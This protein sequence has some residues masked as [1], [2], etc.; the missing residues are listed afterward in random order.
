MGE[1]YG[2]FYT[3]LKLCLAYLANMIGMYVILRIAI[4]FISSGGVNVLGNKISTVTLSIVALALYSYTLMIIYY[5][6]SN[7]SSNNKNM[8]ITNAI[9]DSLTCGMLRVEVKNNMKILHASKGFVELMGYTSDYDVDGI[10][11]LGDYLVEGEVSKLNRLINDC[12]RSGE[13]TVNTVCSAIIKDGYGISLEGNLKLVGNVEKKA[14]R[15]ILDCVVVDM[16]KEVALSNELS[17]EK[18]RYRLISEYS[19][20]IIIEV[21]VHGVSM[22]T[23]SNFARVFGSIGC[24]EPLID[25]LKSNK[26]ISSDDANEIMTAAKRLL[27][28]EIQNWESEL[29]IKEANDEHHWY[30]VTIMKFT[31]RGTKLDRIMCKLTKIDKEVTDKNKLIE[32]ANKDALTGLLNKEAFM[33]EVNT[34]IKNCKAGTMI[35]FDIDNFKGLNDTLGHLIGDKAL[36]DVAECITRNTREDDVLSRF[37]GDEYCIFL[38][39]ISLSAS[40]QIIERIRGNV[41]KQYKDE[42]KT[43]EVTISIGA[44]GYPE[45]GNNARLLLQKADQALYKAK[46]SGKNQAYFM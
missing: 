31:D 2:K 37:G 35:F 6:V 39:N 1:K 9:T 15:L 5:I 27:A 11:Y 44:V 34:R 40:R 10:E 21:N 30:R 19:D 23:S 17:N 12:Y 13:H 46:Q 8:R 32:K 16:S 42:E 33:K 18:E 25:S 3:A 14:G 38:S 45:S 20:D 4:P 43:F 41:I 7:V 36:T 29:Q 26:R 22:Y 24:N 28:G